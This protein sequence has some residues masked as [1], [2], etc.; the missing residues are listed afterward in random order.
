MVI[1]EQKTETHFVF[2]SVQTKYFNF[3]ETLLLNYS[4]TKLFTEFDLNL[5]T[6]FG[7]NEIIL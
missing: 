3:G 6:L 2:E 4:L 5:Q 1:S 7:Q